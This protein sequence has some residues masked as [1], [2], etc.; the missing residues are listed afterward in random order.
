MKKNVI[1]S[2]IIIFLFIIIL[3]LAVH[4]KDNQKEHNV[5]YKVEEIEIEEIYRIQKT[6]ET[7]AIYV[8]RPSCPFCKE[9]YKQ[10][11]SIENKSIP[12]YYLNSITNYDDSPSE[13]KKFRDEYNIK[14]VPSFKVFTGKN[15]IS[16]LEINNDT[17]TSNIE[18]FLKTYKDYQ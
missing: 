3:S 4:N 6:N 9:F 7:Y 18:D 1:T 13:I 14:F 2:I 11:N 12:V 5:S 10:L 16:E 15:V 8:G 17:T